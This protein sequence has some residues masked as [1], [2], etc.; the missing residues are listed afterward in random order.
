[1]SNANARMKQI[2]SEREKNDGDG[3]DEFIKY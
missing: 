2:Y 1:M 3:D